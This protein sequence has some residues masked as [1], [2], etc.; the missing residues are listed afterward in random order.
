V[1]NLAGHLTATFG[2]S[3]TGGTDTVP[4][5]VY[6]E[7]TQTFV[8]DTAM[9]EKLATLNPNAAVAIAQRLLE[10]NDRGYWRPSQ[11]ML[12]RLRDATAELE[13]RLEGVYAG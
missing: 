11:D 5:F 8:L 13:D 10:A 9:R 12:D 3:A 2:W 6:T 7:V 4:Q 1:R